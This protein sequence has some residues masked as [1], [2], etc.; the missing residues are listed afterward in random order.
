MRCGKVTE[1]TK[2]HGIGLIFLPPYSPNL[3]LTERFWK[4]VKSK[5]LNAACHG[6]SE[7]FKRAIDGCVSKSNGKHKKETD[8]LISDN[9]QLFADV[10]IPAA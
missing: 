2:E 10:F 4:L 7:D 8:S 1:F 6:T 5:A 9:F 3:N